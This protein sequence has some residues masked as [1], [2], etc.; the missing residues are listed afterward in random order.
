MGKPP[1]VQPWMILISTVALALGLNR[2]LPWP[3]PDLDWLGTLGGG[4]FALGILLLFGGFGNLIKAFK[5]NG[6]WD[7]DRLIT[8]GFLKVSRNPLYLGAGLT[9]IGAGL[10]SGLP[11]L[12]LGAFIMLILL[13]YLVVPFEEKMLKAKFGKAW[14]DYA[15]KTPRW[16]GLSR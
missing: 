12:I 15:R 2:L 10:L 16:L 13:N 9:L 4:L 6:V 1:K 11:W 8:D 14:K 3:L 5:A 7:P